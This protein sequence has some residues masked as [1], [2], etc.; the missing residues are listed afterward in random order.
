MQEKG[1][2]EFGNDNF[3]LLRRHIYGIIGDTTKIAC[4]RGVGSCFLEGI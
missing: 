2:S 1:V 3:P 4:V